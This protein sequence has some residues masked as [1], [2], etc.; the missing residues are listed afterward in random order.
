MKGV[1]T[2]YGEWCVPAMVSG[3]IWNSVS[4]S[5]SNRPV[6]VAW[7]FL[8]G[9]AAAGLAVTIALWVLRQ[10][11]GAG[12]RAGDDNAVA[13]STLGLVESI[14]GELQQKVAPG[15]W[16]PR[17]RPRQSKPSVHPGFR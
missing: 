7:S 11:C 5:N 8:R 6:G 1:Y 13:T 2:N 16:F 14:V 17:K 9:A 15:L 12:C 3:S 4:E 10:V